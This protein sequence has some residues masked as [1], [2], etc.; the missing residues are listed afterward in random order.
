MSTPALVQAVLVA[1]AVIWAVMFAARKFMPVTTRRAQ[2][3]VV[4]ALD[5]PAAP[6]W[7]REFARRAQPQSTSGGSCG[8]GCSACGGCAAAAAKPVVEAQPLV[9][10]PR[11]KS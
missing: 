3:R 10:R 5:F 8:D 9:F 6:L 4:A 7:L 1:L 2:A 11:P